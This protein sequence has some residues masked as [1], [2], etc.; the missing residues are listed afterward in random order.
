MQASQYSN[1]VNAN[2]PASIDAANN[3]ASA[4]VTTTQVNTTNALVQQVGQQ[5]LP[6]LQEDLTKRNDQ[7]LENRLVQA[8]EQ[9]AN[10][11]KIFAQFQKS[12]QEM[13]P[14]AEQTQTSKDVEKILQLAPSLAMQV[15]GLYKF[16]KGIPQMI[17]RAE[18]E[19]KTRAVEDLETCPS[20]VALLNRVTQLEKRVSEWLKKELKAE[21]FSKVP[22]VNLLR[23]IKL[24]AEPQFIKLNLSDRVSI[25]ETVETEY[26]LLLGEKSTLKSNLPI[27]KR[28]ELLE[29]F[30]EA[31]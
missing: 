28:I 8:N 20:D 27:Q 24:I 6:K 2:A 5:E 4:E 31:Q 9:I 13:Q 18:E 14:L 7:S 10:L 15:Q 17:S 12:L 3:Q 29:K 26:K 19:V 25:L 21:Y 1:C 16:T 30:A 11:I 23:S 22:L